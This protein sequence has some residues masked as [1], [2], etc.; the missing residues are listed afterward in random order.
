M[1][2]RWSRQTF[3]D[4]EFVEAKRDN[5]ED[6]TKQKE[7]NNFDTLNREMLRALPQIK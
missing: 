4:E 2:P 6:G 7:I 1:K 3:V 5:I